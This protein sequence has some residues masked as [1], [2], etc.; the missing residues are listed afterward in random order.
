V[1]DVCL[2]EIFCVE[3]ALAEDDL[4]V[5]VMVVILDTVGRANEDDIIS[6]RIHEKI[7]IIQSP[8]RWPQ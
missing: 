6:L 3:L 5:V 8:L 4:V 2:E 7:R 1:D